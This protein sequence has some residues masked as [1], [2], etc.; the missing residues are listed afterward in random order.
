MDN[1]GIPATLK[2]T[3]WNYGSN[4]SNYQATEWTPLKYI[5]SDNVAINSTYWYLC[6]LYQG[7]FHTVRH[8]HLLGKKKGFTTSPVPSHSA[9]VSFFTRD[10][11]ITL[12]IMENNRE[13]IKAPTARRG[14]R[15][16]A[17]LFFSRISSNHKRED[18][19]DNEPKHTSE[20]GVG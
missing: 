11:S 13:N 17:R 10:K 14:W 18:K 2:R 8:V 1:E 16:G 9:K 15:S 6:H 5:C 12:L 3:C 4:T 19:Q 20:L 7:K